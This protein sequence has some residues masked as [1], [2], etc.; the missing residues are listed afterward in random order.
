MGH[1]SEENLKMTVAS[2][3]IQASAALGERTIFFSEVIRGFIE[4]MVFPVPTLITRSAEQ[5]IFCL[6]T[7]IM[8]FQRRNVLDSLARMLEDQLYPATG[9][10]RWTRDVHYLSIDGRTPNRERQK[11]IDLFFLALLSFQ[12]SLALNSVL[13]TTMSLGKGFSFSTVLLLPVSNSNS[14]TDLALLQSSMYLVY[15]V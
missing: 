5:S 13:V 9:L 12:P 8:I 4:A 14:R 10:A 2:S 11:Y 15:S 7:I 3:L 6:S 1:D